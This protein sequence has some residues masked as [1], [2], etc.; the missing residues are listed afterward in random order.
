MI[1]I[2][3]KKYVKLL[4]FKVGSQIAF[5]FIKGKITKQLM[6]FRLQIVNKAK[7]SLFRI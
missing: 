2:I 3:H 4:L 6:F 7:I 1:L 5:N